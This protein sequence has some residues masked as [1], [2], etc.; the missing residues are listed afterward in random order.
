MS[1]KLPWFYVKKYYEE[2]PELETRRQHIRRIMS[3]FQA[4]RNNPRTPPEWMPQ[5]IEHPVHPV[6]VENLF[7]GA[8]PSNRH[9][10]LEN[11]NTFHS[12]QWTRR[13]PNGLE[14]YLW[15]RYYT[16][17]GPQMDN[18]NILIMNPINTDEECNKLA[19]YL[20]SLHRKTY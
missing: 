7:T 14:R 3:A 10:N 19:K 11:S 9:D 4:H 2:N 12:N 6:I 1:R 16:P 8:G 5:Y 20:Y 18:E 15:P 17:I 13:I